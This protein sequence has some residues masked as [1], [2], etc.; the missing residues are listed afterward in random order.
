MRSDDEDDQSSWMLVVVRTL[1][2]ATVV[3]A[4]GALLMIYFKLKQRPRKNKP[5]TFAFFHPHASGGGGGERVLWKMIQYLQLQTTLEIVIYTIDPPS[6]CEKELRRDAERRFDVSIPRP[7][8]LVSLEEHRDC[9]TPQP[10]LSLVLESYGTMT[11][12]KHA[13]QKFQPDVF[14]D[15]TGC[16]FTFAVVRWMCPDTWIMAYVHY[17]T[18]S[19]DMMAWEWSRQ[20]QQQ[21]SFLK[22]RLRTIIKLVYYWCFAIGYGLVGS[23][24]DLVMVNS[25]WT[26]RHIASLWRFSSHPIRIVYPPCRVPDTLPTTSMMTRRKPTIVSIG[27]FRPE[28][29]HTLQIQAI[30]KLLE[31]HPEL[32]SSNNTKNEPQLQLLLIGSCRN[33]AD[34]GRLEELQALVTTLELQDFV[35]FNVNPPYQELQAVM[36]DASMGIH[37]MRQEHFGIGIVEMMAAGLLVI[38]HNSGGPKTDIVDPGVSGFLATSAEEFAEAIHQAMT[39]DKVS[40]ERMRRKAMESAVRFSDTAFDKQLG[41]ALSQLSELLVSF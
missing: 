29:N 36:M 18:I 34:R 15:T 20:Q 28:K 33:D 11:L 13:L 12:A 27:Q 7:V 25:T 4:L 37:T 8:R 24:A 17:P 26:Y 39:L 38:A 41:N 6:T 10:F 32:K 1:V 14:C 21:E 40:E 9:L 16:A 5:K 3:T 22:R 23:L 35:S 30:S 2:M 19:T 31:K